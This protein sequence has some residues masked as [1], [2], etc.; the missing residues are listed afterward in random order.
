MARQ[1]P[2][3]KDSTTVALGLAQIRIGASATNIG[4]EHPVLASS[5]SV[6]ALANTKFTGNAEYYR[7]ESGFPL[8]EDA[9]FPLRES[10]MMECGFREITP[11][12]FALARGLDPAG[13]THGHTGQIALGT[14]TA[15]VSVRME[16]VYTYPDGTN[17]MVFI[18]PRGQVS[19]VI[20]M[21]FAEEEPAAV[22]VSIESKRADG[23]ISGGAHAWDDKPLGQIYWTTTTATY[24]TTSTTTTTT[25]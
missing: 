16:A 12:N 25:A 21:E 6:G 5:D 7:L 19:A 17:Q 23:E 4:Q 22:A 1:G 18:F 3:T 20:E 10:A 24:T 11:R 13:Y 15:P 14:L 9:V 2:V 8:L